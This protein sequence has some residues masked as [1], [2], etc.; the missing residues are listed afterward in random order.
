MSQRYDAQRLPTTK[1]RRLQHREDAVFS[2]TVFRLTAREKQIVAFVLLAF[3][4]GWSVRQW[5]LL[6]SVP[7]PAPTSLHE[8][9]TELH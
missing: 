4:I 5:H 8:F 2:S 3:L 9:P 7:E 1:K 6:R